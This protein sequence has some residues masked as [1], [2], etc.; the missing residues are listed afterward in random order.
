M[1]IIYLT[2]NRFVIVILKYLNNFSLLI[3]N[4]ININRYNPHK[5]K[6]SMSYKSVMDLRDQKV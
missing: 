5:R 3:F 6:F 1:H 2:G 4:A